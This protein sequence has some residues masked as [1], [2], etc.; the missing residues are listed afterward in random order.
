VERYFGVVEE[1]FKRAVNGSLIHGTCEVLNVMTYLYLS[2][3]GVKKGLRGEC[4]DHQT[5]SQ[6]RPNR[7][8]IKKVYCFSE[9]CYMLKRGDFAGHGVNELTLVVVA[10]LGYCSQIQ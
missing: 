5:R 4:Q 8:G 1:Q 2:L 3:F 9:C 10:A 7:Y 6:Q